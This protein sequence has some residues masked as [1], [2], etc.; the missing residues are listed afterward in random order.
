MCNT[1]VLEIPTDQIAPLR[2]LITALKAI[3][4]PTNITFIPD[5]IRIINMDISHTFNHYIS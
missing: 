5:A 4:L 1:N 3:R 2:T